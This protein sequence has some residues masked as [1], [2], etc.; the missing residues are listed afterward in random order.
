MKNENFADKRQKEGMFYS[1]IGT[2]IIKGRNAL[3]MTQETLADKLGISR[4][5]VGNIES[6]KQRLPVHLMYEVAKSLHIDLMDLFKD[7]D[8]PFAKQHVSLP[9]SKEV[10]SVPVKSSMEI[11]IMEIL[12]NAYNNINDVDHFLEVVTKIAKDANDILSIQNEKY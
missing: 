12:A 6:G 7:I 5:S 1:T 11:H 8:R 4:V 3:K 2:N 9:E 10:E